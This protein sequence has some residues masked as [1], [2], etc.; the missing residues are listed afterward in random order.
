MLCHDFHGYQLGYFPNG[1]LGHPG[2]GL[3]VDTLPKALLAAVVFLILFLLF[4]Y[5]VVAT[6]RLHVTIARALLQGAEELPGPSSG[7]SSRRRSAG[8]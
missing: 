1:P 4:N 8:W 3:Y 5:A 7:S 6:A 2:Y